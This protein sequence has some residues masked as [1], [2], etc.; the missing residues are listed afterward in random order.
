MKRV[1]N[2]T[3]RMKRKQRKC[4][5]MHQQ[6]QGKEKRFN[7]YREKKKG[8]ANK[9]SNKISRGTSREKTSRKTVRKDR[10][11]TLRKIKKKKETIVQMK[12][13]IQSLMKKLQIT[14]AKMKTIPS[15]IRTKI[16]KYLLKYA[17]DLYKAKY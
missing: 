2:M 14:D 13:K 10:A 3:E 6:I 1:A 5:K 11:K 17:N 15:P 7:K 16:F 12:R 8:L 9:I 4:W